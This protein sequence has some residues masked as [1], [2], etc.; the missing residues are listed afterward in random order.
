M[1][2]IPHAVR[3]A[4]SPE[5]PARNPNLLIAPPQGN[6][7]QDL[8]EGHR[9]YSYSDR[10]QDYLKKYA[11]QRPRTVTTNLTLEQLHEQLTQFLEMEMAENTWKG[12]ARSWAEFCRFNV[13]KGLEP[14]NL[15]AATFIVGLFY[16]MERRKDI[17]LPSI[18]QYAK[19]ISAVG[20][21]LGD[22]WRAGSSNE[23]SKVMHILKGMGALI[24]SSQAKPMIRE[25]VYQ[26]LDKTGI[27]EADKMLIYFLWKTA[28]R[29]DDA[30]KVNCKDCLRIRTEDNID[31]IIIVWR[32]SQEVGPGS[33]R[34]KNSKGYVLTCALDCGQLTD[35][36]WKYIN[37]RKGKPFT[38]KT[39]EQIVTL[40]R[41]LDPEYS[42][43]SPKR[44]ALNHLGRR[45]VEWQLVSRMARH[46]NPLY[47]LPKQTRTYFEPEVLAVMLN[48]HSATKIL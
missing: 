3:N 29:D 12:Y 28:S 25:H 19:N 24:P 27:S 44:G 39:Q 10:F 8:S 16:D 13:S 14:T 11:P 9:V 7:M 32:P 26:A 15:G 46:S 37:G 38:D 41:R 18:H 43:H 17:D 23:L 31:L 5:G 40:L 4:S 30:I 35:R 6:V 21:R 48:T 34:Q 42:G 45:G 22:A 20:N 1:Q 47:D 2:E 36:L 33:G